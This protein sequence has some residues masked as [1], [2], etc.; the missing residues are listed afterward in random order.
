MSYHVSVNIDIAKN[1]FMQS[2]SKLKPTVVNKKLKELSSNKTNWSG[3]IIEYADKIIESKALY[4]LM[5][6]DVLVPIFTT[7][8]IV[9]NYRLE[10]PLNNYSDSEL[11]MKVRERI[12]SVNENDNDAS[13]NSSISLT[14]DSENKEVDD[15]ELAQLIVL[16][17]ELV[18]NRKKLLCSISFNINEFNGAVFYIT[19]DGHVGLSERSYNRSKQNVT[20]NVLQC[21]K[22]MN[23]IIDRKREIPKL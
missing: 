14:L 16:M 22:F 10:K 3:K 21:I 19:S 4:K 20:S 2:L 6:K 9:S 17:S 5:G 13:D 7:S 23:D 11:S 8:K 18:K 12:N 1:L 15:I